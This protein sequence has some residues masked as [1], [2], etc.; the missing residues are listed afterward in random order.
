MKILN[1]S[2]NYIFAFFAYLRRTDG[3]FCRQGRDTEIA[4]PPK[5]KKLSK[6]TD[7]TIHW[8]A[9]EEHFLV[10]PLFFRLNHFGGKNAFLNFSHKT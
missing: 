8:N 4:P 9:L 6:P 10:V 3:D 7:V 1:N 2:L 5:K